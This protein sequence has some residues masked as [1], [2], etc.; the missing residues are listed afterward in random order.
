[1][2][3][4]EPLWDVFTP[5]VIADLQ[6]A[7]SPSERLRTRLAILHAGGL[8]PS[9]LN[10]HLRA[11]KAAWEAYLTAAFEIGLF[12]GQH[13]ADLR[14]RLTGIDDD[15]FFSAISECFAA[16]YLAGRRRLE[17][18]PRPAGRGKHCLEFSIKCDSGDI[19]VEVKAPY[20]PLTDKFFWGDDSDLLEGALIEANRQFAKG[21]RNLLVV[22]PRVRLSIFPKFCRT[23]I[24]RAF[25]GEDVI[26]IPL[27]ATGGPAGPATSVEIPAGHQT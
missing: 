10:Q 16:W 1:M 23:P 25:V 24:E 2:V 6:Q 20:R 22:H 18:R 15:N 11:F 13:G 4:T 21:Q 5:K 27:T 17:L 3:P 12:G 19:N 9:P 8:N 7:R 26:R 14:A